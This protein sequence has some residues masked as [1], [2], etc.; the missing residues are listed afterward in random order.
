LLKEFSPELLFLRKSEPLK[1]VGAV[2]RDGQNLRAGVAPVFRRID[3]GDDAY[4]FDRFLIRR[5]DAR[6]RASGCSRSC[7]QSD[8]L[9]AVTRWPLAEIW[10]D[11]HD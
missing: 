9:L 3:V 5:D 11:S 1:L 7:R 8:S 2:L 10:R 6:R 4:L